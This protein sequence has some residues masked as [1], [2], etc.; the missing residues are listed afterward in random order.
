MV[1]LLSNQKLESFIQAIAKD[2]KIYAL[3][4]ADDQF[5]L[6]APDTWSVQKHCLGSYRPVE[7]LKSVVF[8]PRESMGALTDDSSPE[9]QPAIVFGVKNCDLS[10]LRIHDYVFLSDPVDPYY[11][12]ARDNTIIVSSD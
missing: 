5:H 1:Y 8:K 12:A 4:K 7:P 2:R 6:V 11:K 9:A 3:E 10:A